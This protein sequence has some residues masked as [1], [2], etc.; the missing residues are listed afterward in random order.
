MDS[1]V[2]EIMQKYFEKTIVT[3]LDKEYIAV[4]DKGK[5]LIY[6]MTDIKSGILKKIVGIDELVKKEFLKKTKNLS[7][8]QFGYYSHFREQ[9]DNI[10]YIHIHRSNKGIVIEKQNKKKIG[11]TLIEILKILDKDQNNDIIARKQVKFILIMLEI[12]MRHCS[13]TTSVITFITPEEG[14]Y[15]LK[16]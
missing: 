8:I 1:K 12:M 6:K 4:I 3:I 10:F 2:K 5:N 16:N 9:I 11:D 15:F 7:K 14:A 13:A